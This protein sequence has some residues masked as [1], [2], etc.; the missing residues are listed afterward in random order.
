MKLGGGACEGSYTYWHGGRRPAV[1]TPEASWDHLA[2]LS[3]PMAPS[4]VLA[5]PFCG[6]FLD[7]EA[8]AAQVTAGSH[9]GDAL[10]PPSAQ[11]MFVASDWK[12]VIGVL[13][14]WWCGGALTQAPQVQPRRSQG[15]GMCLT[16]S[17]GCF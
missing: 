13:E 4:A 7:R 11:R 1:H 5:F 14:G 16:P 15:W 8:G 2:T 12:G 17:P 10:H 6:P 3:V 9:P